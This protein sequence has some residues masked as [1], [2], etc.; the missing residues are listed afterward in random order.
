MRNKE[1]IVEYIKQTVINQEEAIDKIA[2]YV[3]VIQRP[4]TDIDRF[5]ILLS[6]N[7]GTGKTLIAKQI[8]EYVKKNTNYKTQFIPIIATDFTQ[9]GYKGMS[10]ADMSNDIKKMKSSG[11]IPIL[12]IDEMDKLLLSELLFKQSVLDEFLS[13]INE[14]FVIMAGAFSNKSLDSIKNKI[15]TVSVEVFTRIHDY[16]ELKEVDKNLVI[17]KA[18]EILKKEHAEGDFS[19]LDEL[20]SDIDAISYRDISTIVYKIDRHI[21]DNGLASLHEFKYV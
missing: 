1:D 6:G 18:K 17:E 11:Q 16:I 4:I 7:S 21:Y 12:F 8:N 3:N 9:E 14:N 15:R 2:Y 19:I 10:I 20:L 13:I 5:T